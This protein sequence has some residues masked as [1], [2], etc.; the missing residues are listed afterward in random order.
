MSKVNIASILRNFDTAIDD[1]RKLEYKDT[2]IKNWKKLIEHVRSGFKINFGNEP[3][4]ILK[5]LFEN[6]LLNN[7]LKE[8]NKPLVSKDI[9]KICIEYFTLEEVVISGKLCN[10]NE[11]LYYLIYIGQID[12]IFKCNKTKF[13]YENEFTSILSKYVA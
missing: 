4:D 8:L 11:A 6:H 7:L 13:S 1:I 3:N 12:L 2:N 10:N 5:S 9:S